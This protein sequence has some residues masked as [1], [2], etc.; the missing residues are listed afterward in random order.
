MNRATFIEQLKQTLTLLEFRQG[1]KFAVHTFTSPFETIDR[2]CQRAEKA[3]SKS[4]YVSS[5]VSRWLRAW[6]SKA[7]FA[8]G[9]TC[10]AW[11]IDCNFSRQIA[12]ES[13][14]NDKTT[15]L[16]LGA[17]EAGMSS[18]DKPFSRA[19]FFPLMPTPLTTSGW[20]ENG[21]ARRRLHVDH[22]LQGVGRLRHHQLFGLRDPLLDQHMTFAKDGRGLGADYRQDGLLDARGILSRHTPLLQGR[23]FDLEKGIEISD[24]QLQGPR[25]Q[26]LLNDLTIIRANHGRQEGI[27]RPRFVPRVIHLLTDGCDP[28]PERRPRRNRGNKGGS[29]SARL[30]MEVGASSAHCIAMAAP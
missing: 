21:Q 18:I 12:V 14:K 1:D 27:D 9:K 19:D 17:F 16:G 10:C 2:P 26:E 13:S 23:E 6:D 7:T 15:E 24:R 4:S 22:I 3:A 28:F 5:R 30:C 11:A 8:N 20:R 25:G 29:R